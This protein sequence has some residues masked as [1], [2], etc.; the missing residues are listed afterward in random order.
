M[1]HFT[2]DLEGNFERQWLTTLSASPCYLVTAQAEQKVSRVLHIWNLEAASVQTPSSL[3]KFSP[4]WPLPHGCEQRGE[5]QWRRL[6]EIDD[7]WRTV[8]IIPLQIYG[9]WG[10]AP[11]LTRWLPLW[12]S[13]G[14]SHMCL[15]AYFQDTVPRDWCVLCVIKKQYNEMP[16]FPSLNDI[17]H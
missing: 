4:K 11:F 17:L 8:E 12:G 15:C 7:I 1:I 10:R 14:C 16:N 6:S 5:I 9:V 13:A 3:T 2:Q